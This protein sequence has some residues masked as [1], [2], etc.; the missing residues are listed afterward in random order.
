ML[1]ATFLYGF[2]YRYVTKSICQMSENFEVICQ[3]SDILG[4]SDFHSVILRMA[5]HI[6]RMAMMLTVLRMATPEYDSELI[7]E[8]NRKSFGATNDAIICSDS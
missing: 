2:L 8:G 1:Y 3:M 5:V 6:E 7:D 4:T